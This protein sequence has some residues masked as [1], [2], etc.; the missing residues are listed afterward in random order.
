[1]PTYSEIQKIK[2]NSFKKMEFGI[3]SIN[4]DVSCMY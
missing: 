4:D 3:N 1:M 2:D